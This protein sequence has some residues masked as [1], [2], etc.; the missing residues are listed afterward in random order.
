MYLARSIDSLQDVAEVHHSLQAPFPHNRNQ[1]FL[2]QFSH[3]ITGLPAYS[4]G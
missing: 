3:K 4:D 2:Q 1:F